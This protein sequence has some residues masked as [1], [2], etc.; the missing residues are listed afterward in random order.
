MHDEKPCCAADALRYI[1]RV[2]VNGRLTGI[3]LL[4]PWFTEVKAQNLTTDARIQTALIPR[5]KRDPSVSKSVEE[6]C[7]TRPP[8]RVTK[9]PS[10][11]P[12]TKKIED[13]IEESHGKD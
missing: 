7:R 8:G 11:K 3:A 13:P 10:Q 4:D 6:E 1:R 12:N 5:T 2:P 9:K